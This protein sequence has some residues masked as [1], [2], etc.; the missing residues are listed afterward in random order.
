MK[1]ERSPDPK[2]KAFYETTLYNEHLTLT[3]T[4]HFR[5]SAHWGTKTTRLRFK[6]HIIIQFTQYTQVLIKKTR[7]VWKWTSL[8]IKNNILVKAGLLV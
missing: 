4:Q 3:D 2:K 1:G 7:T 6:L 8:H 5:Q